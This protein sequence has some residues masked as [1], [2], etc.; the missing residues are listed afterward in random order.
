MLELENK[1]PLTQDNLESLNLTHLLT[2]SDLKKLGSFV[3]EGYLRDEASRINWKE[4]TDAAMDLAMQITSYK[5]FP[6]PDCSNVAFPLVTIAVLQFHSRAYPALLSGPNIVKC[7]T[8]GPD[9]Q[10]IERA[11]ANR[12]GTHMS[13]QCLE[14]DTDWEEQ[15]D[16]LL[17]NV[18][19]VGTA[20]T[21]TYY[22]G[23]SHSDLVMAKD[24]VMNYYTKSVDA[25]P[26]KT[27]I[28]PLFHNDI[29]ESV[30]RGNFHDVLSDS[31]FQTFAPGTSEDNKSGDQRHGTQPPSPDATTPF[32]SLEQHVNVDLDQD[33]YAEP[34]IITIEESTQTVLRMVTRFDRLD[35]IETNLDG[36]IIA[37][38]QREFFTKHPF[39]PSPDGGIYDIGFGVLLGP[40]NESVNSIINQL[41]DSGTM[42]TL[43][44]GFLGRGAKIRGGDYS[45]SP[46]EWKRIDSTVD[47]LK[48]AIF[49]LPV[50]EPSNVLF[51]LLGLLVDYTNRIS[52]STEINVGENPGQNTPAETSRTMVTQGQKVYTA[53]YK[54][55]WRSMKDEFKKRYILN[56][57]YIPA[58][59]AITFGEGMKITKDDYLVDPNCVIPAAD[60]TITSEE[61][62]LRK[63]ML[64]KQNAMVTPGYN[65]EELEK[66]FLRALRVDNIERIFPGMQKTGPLPNPKM[67]IEEIK[68]QVK[69]KQ[70]ELDKMMF[71]AELQE[72]MR[73]NQAKILELQA[74]AA[75]EIAQA[76]GVQAGHQLAAFDAAIGAMKQHQELL[77]KKTELMLKGLEL[78][79]NAKRESN[80]EGSSGDNSGG[81]GMASMAGASS[82][83]ATS[84]GTGGSP[85]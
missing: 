55:L 41:I 32:I 73:L 79:Q 35:D 26:R 45:F 50:R 11:R 47:D 83:Q 77:I 18:A 30:K 16:R 22:K 85:Q 6:W 28:I 19:C 8:I 58:E 21:K 23:H 14:E 25:C 72:E 69:I 68:A 43:A 29:Y 4:R 70:L 42:S 10:G 44:G 65:R 3:H 81:I 48:K 36:E 20:F 62:A 74:K 82:N 75:H 64:L 15:H 31:W 5:N 76:K 52:G 59:K 24:L 71:I 60:P 49:P 34:Y 67:Q 38:N 12:I 54:R 61:D 56:G 1:I 80:T 66:D 33:G 57:I 39:I 2:D 46:L 53:I 51:Q 13:W 37:I 27:H 17:I 9:E 7:R 63:A 78:D 40:L 84:S